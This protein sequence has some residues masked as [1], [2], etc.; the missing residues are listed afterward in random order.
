MAIADGVL[1]ERALLVALAECADELVRLRAERDLLR[2]EI[3]AWRALDWELWPTLRT[4]GEL[5]QERA[6][7]QKALAQLDAARAATNAS[8]ALEN[9]R[10]IPCTE[11]S[12]DPC[13]CPSL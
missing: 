5:P 13:I 11:C 12:S 3:E 2:A 9:P 4:P 10:R 7:Y 1:V 8:G 6:E